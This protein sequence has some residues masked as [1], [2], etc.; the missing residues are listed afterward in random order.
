[1]MGYQPL[2]EPG[3]SGSGDTLT[4]SVQ[5]KTRSMTDHGSESPELGLT[6]AQPLTLNRSFN[7]AD[8]E[9]II[10][11][12]LYLPRAPCL[13]ESCIASKYL[14]ETCSDVRGS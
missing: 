10:L 11:G 5:D 8:S 3:L 14:P 4:S 9:L 7:I 2:L 13:G 1:M 6:M 12:N